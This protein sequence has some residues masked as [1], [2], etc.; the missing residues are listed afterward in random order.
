MTNEQVKREVEDE[1][2]KS[3]MQIVYEQ[4]IFQT[5]RTREMCTYKAHSSNGSM[6]VFMLV[7]VCV[8]VCVYTASQLYSI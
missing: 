2:G 5:E 7:C 3:N 8:C 4:G 6:Y 1:R